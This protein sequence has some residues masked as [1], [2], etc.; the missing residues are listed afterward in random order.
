MS[1]YFLKNCDFYFWTIA[2]HCYFWKNV[3]LCNYCEQLLRIV[4]FE[5]MWFYVFLRNCELL[6]LKNC[7]KKNFVWKIWMFIFKNY[8]LL[9]FF[10]NFEFSFLKNFECLCFKILKFYFFMQFWI[11]F[12]EKFWILIFQQ[13][14]LQTC[15][16]GYVDCVE[17]FWWGWIAPWWV[18]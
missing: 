6:F 4:I 10:Y 15:I 3:I 9:F 17:N 7:W 8:E 2:A 12:F 18:E 16:E 5:K 13:L 11:F 14:F 1:V